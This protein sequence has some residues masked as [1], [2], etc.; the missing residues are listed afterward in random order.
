MWVEALRVFLRLHTEKQYET[1]E[2]IGIFYDY[3][4]PQGF[5]LYTFGGTASGYEPLKEMFEGIEKVFKNE[6]DGSLAPLED[7]GNGR[8]HVRPVHIL[9][10]GNLIGNNVVVGGVRRTAEIFLFDEDDY[11]SMFAKYGIN[12]IW[13]EEQH[14]KVVQIVDGLGMKEL[15]K[16]LGNLPVADPMAKPLHHR[17]MS[18]NSVA[19]TSKPDRKVLNLIFELMQAEG[20]P[21][22]IN[23]EEALR[24]RPNAKGLNPLVA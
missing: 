13:N 14:N 2:Q 20:E 6:L 9:D 8:Y 1:V 23:L 11:E 22:L 5:R 10:I 4:R 24:R 7:A 16:T 12:G 15:S 3:I 21:G 18:N 17:R 19:F